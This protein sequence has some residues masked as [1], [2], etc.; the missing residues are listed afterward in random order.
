MGD[1]MTYIKTSMKQFHQSDGIELLN[2]AMKA[3]ATRSLQYDVALRC[4]IKDVLEALSKH[5][6]GSLCHVRVGDGKSKLLVMLL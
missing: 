5:I 2:N 1:I 6:E 3:K 4:T